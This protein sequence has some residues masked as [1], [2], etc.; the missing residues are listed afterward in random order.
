MPPNADGTPTQEEL[1]V[2]RNRDMSVGFHAETTK[3][4]KAGNDEFGE[5]NFRRT[6]TTLQQKLGDA[7]FNYLT[8]QAAQKKGSAHRLLAHL[9]GNENDLEK[10]RGLAPERHG[11]LLRDLERDRL[12]VST[13]PGGSVEKNSRGVVSRKSFFTMM[14]SLTDEEFDRG[15]SE[16]SRFGNVGKKGRRP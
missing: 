8:A 9:A 11:D 5:E 16:H 13:V 1:I 12:G 10:L 2:A 6:R 14:D 4:L 3:I 15:Y 7:G